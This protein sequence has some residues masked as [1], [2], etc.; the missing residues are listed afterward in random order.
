MRI[1]RRTVLLVEDEDSI[2]V[3][4]QAALAREGFDALDARTAAEALELAR[5]VAPDV[6]LLDVMLPDGDGR[7][8]LREIRA[9][10]RVP[11]LM[12]TARDSET[13]LLV[14]IGARGMARGPSGSLDSGGV[15]QRLRGRVRSRTAGGAARR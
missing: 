9:R 7:D 6:V 10:S 8:V 5:E 1:G 3:P 11:V 14:G 13:D 15:H 2:T 4:L 12:L